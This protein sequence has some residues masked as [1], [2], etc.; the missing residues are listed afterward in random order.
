[1]AILEVRLVGAEPG[2]EGRSDDYQVSGE[3]R[4]YLRGQEVAVA[5]RTVEAVAPLSRGGTLMR[6]AQP[7]AADRVEF[8]VTAVRGTQR[9]A[10]A[11]AALSE[12]EVIGQGATPDALGAGR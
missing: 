10:P 7:I 8:T 11:P 3:L 6:L 1:M 5:A 2:Q 12:I 9:G 4:F